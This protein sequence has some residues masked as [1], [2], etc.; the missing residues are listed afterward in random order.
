MD[1]GD[2]NEEVDEEQDDKDDVEDRDE[3][4]TDFGGEDAVEL[5]LDEHEATLI[6]ELKVVET[7]RCLRF[8]LPI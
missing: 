3:G 2:D 6:G 7:T 8:T 1:E 4:D 5:L